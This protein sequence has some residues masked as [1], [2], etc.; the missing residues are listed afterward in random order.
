MIPVLIV[1]VGL[2]WIFSGCV[3]AAQDISNREITTPKD[4]YFDG[5]NWFGSIVIFS[6]RTLIALPFWILFTLCYIIYKF[7]RWTFTVGGGPK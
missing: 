3:I 6:F 7:V 1:T 5:Y 4:L 2:L